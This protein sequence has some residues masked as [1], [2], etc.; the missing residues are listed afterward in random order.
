MSLLTLTF[1][2]IVLGIDNI[3]FI[4]IVANKL[5]AEQQNKARN[6]G[7]LMAMLFR[8]GLL[9]LISWILSLTQPL[10]SIPFLKT[11]GQAVT[12]S[13]KDIILLA[14]GFFLIA[15]AT[16][17]IHHK[18]EGEADHHEI[19]K[20]SNALQMVVI[21]VFLVNVV[22]S[23]DSILTAIGMTQDTGVMMIAVVLSIL[24]MMIYAGPVSRFINKHPSFQM[25]ALSFLI[26][27]GVMLVAESFHQE[28]PKG[29]LYFAIAFSMGVEL[30]NMKFRK[31]QKPL[32][33]HGELEE[34]QDDGLLNKPDAGL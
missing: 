1:L 2:E 30:L 31:N 24:V 19:K 34:A 10:F 14:G 25:L 4:S 32:Q 26:L 21:Q 11:H 12:M 16:S 3:I 17:E 27:I 15:K 20:V 9:F 13:I 6:L 18:L 5:P 7:L 28:V 23:F 8:V 22:F 29:Y 33:L